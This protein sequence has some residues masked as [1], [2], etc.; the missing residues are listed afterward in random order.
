VAGA[1]IGSGAAGGPAIQDAAG[2]AL[3]AD[4]TAI[5]PGG[6][7]FV[8]WTPIYLGLVGYAVWQSL[9]AQKTADRQRRLGYPV[10]A[11]MILNT[12]W[13]VSVQFGMLSLSILLIVSL[14]AVLVAAFRVTTASR[15]KNLADTILADGT[16]GLYLGWACVATAAN[17]TAVLVAAGFRG[18]GWNPDVWAVAVI[19][20]VGAAGF[21]LAI[22]GRGRLAPAL[23]LCWGLIWVAVARLSGELVSTPTAI[24]SFVA[25]AAVA[26]VTVL[27]RLRASRT[28]ARVAD[29]RAA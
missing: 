3:A 12:A 17:I 21:A 18:F 2:G 5:A 27:A 1:F 26:L 19:I 7:A 22:F 25:G 6:P 13:I 16:V 28:S 24:A 20:V 14:L 4:A 8:I 29:P 15:P 23:A 11:S 9:P 10:A